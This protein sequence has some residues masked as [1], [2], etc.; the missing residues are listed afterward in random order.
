MTEHDG[1][2]LDRL[3]E[4]A[5][6]V[7]GRAPATGAERRE[8]P[9]DAAAEEDNPCCRGGVVHIAYR[10]VSD[11]KMYVAYSRKWVEVKYFKPRGLRV[12]CAACRRRIL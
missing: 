7:L 2:L 8:P 11:D 5:L 1:G 3:K 6:R 12:F 9:A 4:L 10:G